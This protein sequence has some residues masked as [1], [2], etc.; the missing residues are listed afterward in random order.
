MLHARHI[1]CRRVS[2]DANDRVHLRKIEQQRRF[3]APVARK[4]GH[5]D[6]GFDAHV[7]KQ[8]RGLRQVGVRHAAAEFRQHRRIGPQRPLDQIGGK[9]AVTLPVEV[10]GRRNRRGGS[11]ELQLTG[12]MA[13]V[14]LGDDGMILVKIGFRASQ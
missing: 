8:A 13:A 10:V 14:Q 6:S 4:V 9:V 7:L 12:P 1:P 5:L 2:A 11:R 3:D